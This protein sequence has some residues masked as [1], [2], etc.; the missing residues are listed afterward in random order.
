M[1]EVLSQS[2]IDEL[3]NKMQSSGVEQATPETVK[4]KEYDFTS[5]RKFT[6]D[7][8]KSLNSI[9]ES[10]SRVVSSYFSNVLR[11][12]CE[13]EVLGIEEQNYFEFSNA[14]PD[15]CLAIMITYDVFGKA[16][17]TQTL[18]MELPT[19]FGFLLVERLMGASGTPFLPDRDYT[20]LEHTLLRN[21]CVNITRLLEES[22]GNS[23]EIKAE[24]NHIETNG[25][26]VQVYSQQDV[27]VI[28][29]I[30]VEE[31]NYSGLINICLPAEN[32]ESIIN[33]FSTQHAV[34]GK[35]KHKH[36]NKENP[37]QQVV[38]SYLKESELVLE[39]ELDVFQITL[40]DVANLQPG[41]VIA[42]NKRIN[43]DINVNVEGVAWCTAK[44]GE[45]KN[46]KAI[47]V[48]EVLDKIE[49]GR[50]FG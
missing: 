25:R 16:D 10:F 31:E 38:F 42:L 49:G 5:P 29:S 3:L 28:T 35:A 27:T 6:K 22:W 26:M 15:A 21:V 20:E 33:S 23:F 44:L 9:Y 13:M 43:T 8:L 45:H 12:T 18:I 50:S 17:E 2:Q 32:L 46:M 30:K 24:L 36:K 14:L 48:T 11:N 4:V 1:P 39:A 37:E 40:S 7:Q 34:G 19:A 47:K 41:D